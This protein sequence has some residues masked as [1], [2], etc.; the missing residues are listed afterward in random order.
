M[1]SEGWIPVLDN[2]DE[3]LWAGATPPLL[4][5]STL[6]SMLFRGENADV[7]LVQ[8]KQVPSATLLRV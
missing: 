3:D 1:L 6:T 2:C 7:G 8:T 4:R 5:I